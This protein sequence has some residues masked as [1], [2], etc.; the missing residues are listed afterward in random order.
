MAGVLAEQCRELLGEDGEFAR[1]L[2][3]FKPR[4]AQI[5]MS[6]AVAHAIESQSSLVVEAGT[7][8]GKT[9]A[10]LLPALLSDGKVL[11]STAS[12]TLQD[13][14]YQVDLP[15]LMRH[16]PPRRRCLL[17]GRSNYL[18]LQR[19]EAT[20]E[21]Y[22]VQLQLSF[23]DLERVRIWAQQTIHGD[24]SELADIA[25]DAPIWSMVTSTRDSCLNADC[26][27]YDRCF[28]IKARNRAQDADIVVVNHHLFLADCQAED[29]QALLPKT[30][31]YI[32][33]E[34]HQVPDIALNFWGERVSASQVSE[35]M[36]T[37]QQDWHEHAGDL[38][39]P[40][41]L[42]D[43]PLNETHA[44]RALLPEGSS[45]EDFTRQTEEIVKPVIAQLVQSL[46]VL[47]Q[48]LQAQ[49][50][51][52]KVLDKLHERFEDLIEL[53]KSLS[54]WRSDPDVVHWFE[55][56]RQGW[57]LAKTPLSIE[58]A[59]AELV[60]KRGGAWV[61]TSATLAVQ[62]D[63]SYFKSQL[64][65]HEAATLCLQSPFDY[66]SQALLYAPRDMPMPDQAQ[67]STRLHQLIERLVAISKG[68]AFIL[69]TSHKALQEAAKAL[70][71]LPWPLLVQ[72]QQ[73]RHRLLEDFRR[74]GN[75]VLLGTG[76][77]WE[78][79]DVAGD[80][81]SLVVIDRIPFTSPS[82]P[83]LRAKV[84]S[85]EAR[86][87]R[88]FFDLQLPLAAMT[89]KQGSGR[90]IR[91]ESDRGVL[92]IA[93]PRICMQ[94]YADALVLSLPMMPR[95]HQ[96]ERVEAFFSSVPSQTIAEVKR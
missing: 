2:P 13:Q 66:A 85:I 17:K 42:I 29:G 93:D 4:S 78:G 79:V 38:E 30:Q 65:I 69:F 35:L 60:S 92:V 44:L 76:S 70:T 6:G 95:T 41:V 16:V 56:S 96:I 86:G 37:L 21:F 62:S 14:L 36:R 31:T 75:A 74:K 26:P 18:C 11:I 61:F 89:L 88:P 59:F 73:P 54:T 87:G 72:G 84:A 46:T 91:T 15:E 23:D 34:A 68:R 32:F 1:L 58:Q 28:L 40:A 49:Q 39:L 83:W 12:R 24:R 19:L 22:R 50:G 47:E 43:A 25:E 8:T 53:L 63:F 57:T 81:L 33:D 51:R 7:G 45:R 90:L 52:S 9:Y 77:F 5:A 27:Y 3:G 82:D 67:F 48:M 55:T 80:A 64:G 10:Y 20:E 71:T 94:S